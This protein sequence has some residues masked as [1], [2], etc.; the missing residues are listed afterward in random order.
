MIALT[1]TMALSIGTTKAN[2]EDPET[3]ML[4]SEQPFSNNIGNYTPAE[5]PD[6]AATVVTV[7]FYGV[8]AYEIETS[9]NTFQFKGYMW[10]RWAG[11]ADPVSTLEFANSVEEWGL[12]VTNLT[13]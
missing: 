9:S 3:P 6:P 12:L 8:N 10:L 5:T 1:A 4:I 7:G 11:E 13:E 2:A